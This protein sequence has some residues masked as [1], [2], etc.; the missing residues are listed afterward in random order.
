MMD[1]EVVKQEI[2]MYMDLKKG[3]EETEICLFRA[4]G[5]AGEQDEAEA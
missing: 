1:I 2:Q 4:G 3:T 5:K